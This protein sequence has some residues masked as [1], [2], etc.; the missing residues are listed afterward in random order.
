MLAGVWCSTVVWE[1]WNS[2]TPFQSWCGSQHLNYSK[3]CFSQRSSFQF[4]R[5]LL[6]VLHSFWKISSPVV[7]PFKLWSPAN[8]SVISNSASIPQTNISNWAHSQVSVLSSRANENLMKDWHLFLNMT[9]WSQ[10]CHQ[11]SLWLYGQK[12]W[13]PLHISLFLMEPSLPSYSWNIFSR[14][15][16]R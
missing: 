8:S 13:H 5:I 1:D 4:K 7:V 3:P 16:H 12:D 2:S 9:M 14:I 10:Q 15:P 11:L 6:R